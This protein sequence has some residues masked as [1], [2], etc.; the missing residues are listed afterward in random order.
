MSGR[1]FVRAGYCALATAAVL[2]TAMAG[3]PARAAEDRRVA[4]S[5]EVHIGGIHGLKAETVL[6]RAGERFV[7]EAQVAKSGLFA[8]VSKFYRARH[9][10]RGRIVDGRVQPDESVIQIN[11]GNDARAMRA[12]YFDGGALRFAQNP[13]FT[14]RSG[15]EVGEDLLEGAWDPLMAALAVVMDRREPCG[16]PV[17][18]FDGRY[19]FD[20]DMKPLGRQRLETD[21]YRLRGQALL[22]EVRIRRIAGYKPDDGSGDE[23]PNKPARLWLGAVDDTGWMYPLRLEV[24][25]G[26]GTAVGNLRAIDSRPLSATERAAL[27]R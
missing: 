4:L 13:E 1:G 6:Q 10:S 22:C 23:G 20:L 18:I 11:S 7:A 9:V 12:S 25:T 8:I 27:D 21:G 2:T 24:D 17:P 15:R 16:G 3:A 5:Y 14:P 19:R 26:F